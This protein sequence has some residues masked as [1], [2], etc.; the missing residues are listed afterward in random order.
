MSIK[1]G[2]A[3][4]VRLKALK[5]EHGKV[6]MCL[7]FYADIQDQSRTVVPSHCSGD[8]KCS[9]SILKALP[10]KVKSIDFLLHQK[11]WY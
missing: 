6:L 5:W 7:G 10:Q 9:S 11:I 2:T 1:I 4:A 8:H 3:M